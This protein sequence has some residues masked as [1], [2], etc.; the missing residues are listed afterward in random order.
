MQFS[1]KKWRFQRYRGT[2]RTE[3]AKVIHQQSENKDR[4]MD[5]EGIAQ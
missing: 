2:R 1:L 4:P 3:K 5:A